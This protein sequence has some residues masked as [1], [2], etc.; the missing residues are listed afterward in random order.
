MPT[1]KRFLSKI[2]IL[3]LFTLGY[4]SSIPQKQ[5]LYGYLSYIVLGAVLLSLPFSQKSY[6]SII[7]NLFT[8]ASAISTTGLATVS[9]ADS[10]SLIGQVIIMILVQLGGIGYMT[11]S[12][13][14]VLNVTHHF[15]RNENSVLSAEFPMPQGFTLKGLV[16]HIVIFTLAFEAVGALLLYFA[17]LSV[18]SAQPV[19]D[20]VF[21]SV[22]AFCTAGLALYN[23]SFEQFRH[24]VGINIV[25]SGLSYAGGIG[26]IVLLDLA[27]KI[28]YP[29]YRITFTSKIILIITLLLSA[30]GTVQ[31]FILEPS[32]Q[33]LDDYSKLTVSFFQTMSAITT[34]GFNSIPI[35]AL[36]PASLMLIVM[37]MYI[38]ASPSGTGGGLKSTT[39][40]AVFAYVRSRV[41]SERDVVIFG[42]K[43]PKH[44]YRTAITIF[45][46]YTSVL[47][48]G[49]YLL[50]FTEG[51]PLMALLFEASSA[52]GTVGLSM[53]ITGN[54]S[55]FGKLVLVG[56]MFIGRVGVI[57]FG[58][59]LLLKHNPPSVSENDLAV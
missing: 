9:I 28:R 57:T 13:F 25:I 49:T 26:F 54:L 33:H 5:L 10:Y 31:L 44:R 58:N 29:K 34:V 16:K 24:H 50:S 39:L 14:L 6:T 48:L 17:F 51:F 11:I 32:I 1:M 19:W 15:T 55:S 37:L 12:S 7:D 41:S 53:G 18:G 30:F 43:I 46:L 2:S 20:A 42:G 38:G 35:A 4:F 3:K 23:D 21:H 47:F 8:A 40:V 36:H 56:L 52:L 59:A 45:I 22:S 27:R